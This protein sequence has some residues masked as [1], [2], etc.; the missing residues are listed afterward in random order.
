LRLNIK[1]TSLDKF[2]FIK[3]KLESIYDKDNLL[4]SY[5]LLRGDFEEGYTLICKFND[6][7]LI[8]NSSKLLK[9]ESELLKKYGIENS[10]WYEDDSEKKIHKSLNRSTEEEKEQKKINNEK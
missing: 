1:S 6:K 10:R 4:L 8:I 9:E 5:D 3:A 7:Y 2:E